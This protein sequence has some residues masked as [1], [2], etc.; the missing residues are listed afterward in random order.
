MSCNQCANQSE[1]AMQAAGVPPRQ[2][3][4]TWAGDGEGAL[5]EHCP[6]CGAFL[7][8]QGQCLSRACGREALAAVRELLSPQTRR[9]MYRQAATCERCGALKARQEP[10]LHCLGSGQ[11]NVDALPP[12][13]RWLVGDR[14]QVTADELA[15]AFA[16]PDEEGRLAALRRFPGLAAH[17]D[18]AGKAALWDEVRRYPALAL[19][20]HVPEALAGAGGVE[21][22]AWA[23]EQEP[24]AAR[25]ALRALDVIR[26]QR[27]ARE[28]GVPVPG[29]NGARQR[30][31]E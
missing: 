11:V 31:Q 18:A 19:L 14:A 8:R 4:A 26:Q 24:L 25:A 9:E 10:C 27:R 15:R 5:G 7:T 12:E 30:G 3:Q 29:G 21:Y 13:S 28:R 17:L 2:T 1:P 16:E 6:R 23:A 22:L 20:G